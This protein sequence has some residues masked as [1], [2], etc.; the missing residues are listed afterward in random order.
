MNRLR[1]FSCLSLV[2]ALL[3]IVMSS[4]SSNRSNLAYF[5]DITAYSESS[6]L[7]RWDELK[8]SPGDEIFISV[9]SSEP[10]ATAHFNLPAAN[11]ATGG[12]L[13]TSTQPRQLA[14]IVDSKGDI[15]FPTLGEIH[16]EGMTTEQLHDY[17]VKRI[18][19]WVENPS[20]YVKVTNFT[21]N[22]LGEVVRPGRVNVT[23]DR[24]SILDAIAAA[25]DL[26]PYGRR[27]N[28]LLIRDEN[29][30]QK[31]IL[32]DLS[33]SD[34]LTSEYFYLRPNDVVYV[35]PNNVREGIAKYDQSKAYNLSMI[36]TVVSAASVIASLIIALTV[37]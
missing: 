9:T 21:I 13:L 2:V 7:P 34:I 32:L 24:F 11:P 10:A 15:D 5:K 22:M 31:R 30:T 20:V 35:T 19:Q 16:V 29:G 37:K 36:S 28:V 6:T 3:A 18:S 33:N 26:T 25:G 23:T 4:C 8:V 14:Y 17:L 27:D 12:D 1:K